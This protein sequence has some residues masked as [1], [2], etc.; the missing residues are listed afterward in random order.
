MAPQV[1]WSVKNLNFNIGMQVLFRNAEFAI[2]E[3][4]HVALVGRNGC[5]KSTLLKMIAGRI[6]PIDGNVSV[7]N[8]LRISYL[9][10]DFEINRELTVKENIAEGLSFWN[11]LL[12]RYEDKNTPAF[13]HEKIEHLLTIHDAW[14][15]EKKLQIILDRLNLC[16]DM[17]CQNLSGGETRKVALARAIIAEPDLLLLDEPTNHLDVELIQWIEN[18]LDEFKG[19]CLFITHDRYFLDR[20]ADRVVELDNGEFYSYNGSYADFMTGKM[21]RENLQDISEHKR[22]RFLAKEIEW[23]RR[24]PKA[25]LKRNLGRVKNFENISAI[26]APERVGEMELIIPPAARIGNQ[27]V[28]LENINLAF[29]ERSIIK[30]FS[31]EFKPL[32]KVGIIGP[33]GIGKSSLLKIITGELKADSGIIKIAPA[34][35][36]NYIDQGKLKLDEEKTV[37]EEVAGGIESIQLG[38]D[39]I[40]VWGYLKRFLFEDE[41]INTQ[42]KYLSGGEKARIIMAKILK[43]GG[44]FLILDEPTNDLDLTSLRLLEESL[45]N[46]NGTLILV[47]HD[48]YFL[49]RVCDTIIAFEGDGEVYTQ[50]GDYDYYFEKL[51]ERKNLSAAKNQI[52]KPKSTITA[53]APKIEKKQT[54]LSFKEERELSLMEENICAVETRIAEIDELFSLPDFFS[55]YGSQS[56]ELQHEADELRSKLE[57]LYNRWDELEQKKQSFK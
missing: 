33:N 29:G 40:S 3:N 5:G 51:R 34:L 22:R 15:A 20:L 25:R 38:A 28:I 16:G 6:A 43:H 36:F 26:K 8:N 10:Q 44:N 37:V 7:Q 31:H 18:F 48:R 23:I 54:K 12:K 21:E 27:T 52:A 32:S 50:V 42:I 46:Y 1:L 53:V 56:A 30:N 57:S 47:S 14:N 4:E 49:N 9:P 45:I 41:R 17:S 19:S 2:H 35:E 39:K 13:E 11:D 24:S 55:K